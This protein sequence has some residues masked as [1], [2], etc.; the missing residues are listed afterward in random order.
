MAW[1]DAMVCSGHLHRSSLQGASRGV[2]PAASNAIEQ[3]AATPAPV[4]L[5]D[6]ASTSTQQALRLQVQDDGSLR[7]QA[8]SR[9]AARRTFESGQM[10]A[11][12][13]SAAAG[14]SSSKV[15]HAAVTSMR[16]K[17]VAMIDAAAQAW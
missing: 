13:E 5:S 17:N 6:D 10:S 14:G 3:S 11:M 8:L 7:A 12:L 15:Q 4:G 16:L 1:G 9:S 2:G